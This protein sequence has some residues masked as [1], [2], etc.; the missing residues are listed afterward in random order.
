[1]SHAQGGTDEKPQGGLTLSA[2][3]TPGS[4]VLVVL[5]QQRTGRH[6]QGQGQDPQGQDRQDQDHQRQDEEADEHRHGRSIHQGGGSGERINEPG[7]AGRFTTERLSGH[8]VG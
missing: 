5:K 8:E 2:G 7:Q 3:L 1:M 4:S 6:G